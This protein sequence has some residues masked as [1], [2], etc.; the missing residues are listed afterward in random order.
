MKKLRMRVYQILDGDPLS[1]STLSRAVNAL[2]ISVIVLSVFVIIIE[3]H[4]PIYEAGS[5]FFIVFERLSI[6]FFT[7]EF[8]LRLWARGAAYEAANGGS[9]RGRFEY[10][11]SFHGI[12]DL[13]SIAPFYLQ[14]LFPGL[15]LRMLR[16]LR[17]LRLLKLS[18][19]N[20]A[21]ED[22][23]RAVKSER[24][25]FLA[26]LY[27]ILIVLILSSAL[28]YYAESAAQPEKL[29]SIIHA[30]YWSL[31][32]LTTVG[33]G[34]ISPVTPVG[35]LVASFTALLGVA[36]VA[37]FTGIIASSFSRQIARRRVIFEQELEKAYED[38]VL[39][40]DEDAFLT[41]LKTRFDL[42]DEEVENM[43]KRAI[44]S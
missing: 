7:F 3:S 24:H 29:A 12:I 1:A 22:L 10:L 42:S 41:E 16:I 31:I 21:L 17:L 15:D 25:S 18:R 4:T 26:T 20:S 8:L 2:I 44:K 40:K 36:T 34:D 35:Q 32:T 43:R 28:L 38:G 27:I 39:S 30:M 19:Y 14:L 9:K 13:L 33:Y 5:D 6:A 23:V 37:M 11:M